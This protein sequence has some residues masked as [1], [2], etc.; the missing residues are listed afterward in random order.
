MVNTSLVEKLKIKPGQHIRFINSPDGFFDELGSLPD[1][2]RL[3]TE[4]EGLLVL[5][6]FVSNSKQLE[7]NLPAALDSLKEDGLLWISYPKKSSKIE[8]GLKGKTAMTRFLS[9]KCSG[10]S[11]QTNRKPDL[12]PYLSRS[13]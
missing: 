13:S 5:I 8:T 10:E 7:E 12:S 4:F 1:G 9:G 3:S 6:L 2:V 11:L